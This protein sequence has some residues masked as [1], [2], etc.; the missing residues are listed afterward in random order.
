MPGYIKKLL[1]RIR[2]NG[3]KGAR[4]PSIYSPPNYKH[5]TAQTATVDAT[6]LATLEQQKE[7]QVVVGTLLYYA[8]T[9]DPS[10]LTVVHELGSVQAA[11]SLQDMLKMERLLQYTSVHQHHGLR[12]HASNM[13]LQIQ[14][15]AS[16][17]SRT[18]ARSVLGG[19]HYLGSPA[20]ING[21]FF[22]TSKIISCIVTSAAEAELGAAFQNTQ[23]GAQFRNTLTELGYPQQATI[24]LVDNTVAEGLATDTVNARRS[25]SMDVRFFWLR[26][27]VKKGEFLIKHIPGRW[28]ISDFFTKPL[29]KDKFD[30]FVPFLIVVIDSNSTTPKRQTIVMSKM[31]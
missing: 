10:I 3:I 24:I 23:K 7:L 16:Y 22:C 27:R 2:P 26:D 25:K 15:D 20:Y 4:T 18:K 5:A 13:Q 6:P 9:V 1:K 8:R 21:P 31:L 14:S 28:N 30:Q 17:L 29:P 19:I 12:F 11:P